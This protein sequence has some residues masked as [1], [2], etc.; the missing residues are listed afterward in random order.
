MIGKINK[1]I[2]MSVVDGDG[3][4]TAI[5]LQGCNYNCLYCH[6]PETINPCIHCG[7]CVD[8]CPTKAL[9]VQNRRVVWDSS[10]CIDCD[11]CVEVCPHNSS[12]KITF[13]SGVETAK[14]VEKNMPFITGI[15][16]SGGE[17]TLQHEYLVELY[18]E[19][20]KLG[21]SVL[22]DTNG[23]VDLSLPKYRELVELSDGFMI[24]VK[25]W[26][27]DD[28]H[29][30]TGAYN[31]TVKK[32]LKFLSN[33]DKISEIRTVCIDGIDNESVI[34]SC[35]EFLM[36]ELARKPIA[37]KIIAYRH[38]GVRNEFQFLKSPSA[39]ELRRLEEVAIYMGFSP[40][41]VV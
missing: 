32:N 16:T 1:I 12:P 5:F 21:L 36:Q 17:C 27:K 11:K 38:Y 41:I 7:I 40:V 2:P 3:N 39:E 10:I 33:L 26:N 19:V 24:D 18:T 25:S 37:Y 23:G 31:Y 9:S 29:K 13:L 28:H 8:P 20:K 15:T 14:L 6:N 35:G 4:R 30:L 22:T 34:R